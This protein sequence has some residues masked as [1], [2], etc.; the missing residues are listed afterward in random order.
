MQWPDADD[1]A[2]MPMN[3]MPILFTKVGR[4]KPQYCSGTSIGFGAWWMRDNSFVRMET[5]S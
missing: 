4:H 1:E 2:S 5:Q 3:I